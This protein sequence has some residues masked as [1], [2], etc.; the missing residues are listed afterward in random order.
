MTRVAIYARYSSDLQ[1]NASIEDQIRLC[2]E[3]AERD[4][5]QVVNCYTDAG[6]SGAS[7]MRPGIQMLMLDGQEGKYDIVMTEALDRLSRDQEDIAGIYKRLKFAGVKIVTL[8]EGEVDNLHI[9]LKGTMNAMFLQELANKT[10]RG[11]RGRIEQGKSGGGKTYGYDVVRCFDTNGETVRGERRI[12]PGQA[13]VVMRI[14]TE[15]LAG[16]SPKAIATR[17]NKD[18]VPGPTTKGWGP[19]TIHGNRQ[20]GTGVLNNELYIGRLIWNR[21]RYIKDPDTG[22]RVSRMNPE[23]EWIV[24]DVPELRI[25]DQGLWEAVKAKQGEI[26]RQDTALWQKNRPK[27][28]LSNLLKCGDCSG[29]FTMV[30]KTHVGCF[31]AKNKG[32]C[33][34]QLTMKRDAVEGLVL[35]A[36]QDHLMNDDLVAVFCDEYTRHMNQLHSQHNAAI[37]GYRRELEGLDKKKVKLV[38]AI[39]NGVPGNE[40]KDDF[41]R[42]ATRRGELERLLEN[43]EEMPTLFHP[44]M[45]QRYREEVGNLIASLNNDNKRTEA[46]GILRTMIEK[47]VLAPNEDHTALTVDLVGDLAGILTVATKDNRPLV[48]SGLS[49]LSECS[50]E[51]LVAGVGFEPTTFRL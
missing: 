20:R 16:H 33:D 32:T 41:E 6:L 46:S 9:G 11:L 26:N 39:Y 23:S 44:S 5:W 42:I 4:G 2:R 25:V 13:E 34:N 18:G 1:S 45:A 14:F 50:S 51:A 10:R 19:S 35:T 30:S 15:Y 27:H 17:L 49:V 48:S 24:K 36:L 22:K 31:N 43:A 40:V 12:N 7:M 21:L 29:G 38:E 28:L 37:N 3:R 47:V 8:S